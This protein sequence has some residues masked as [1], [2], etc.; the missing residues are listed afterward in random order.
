MN[1]LLQDFFEFLIVYMDD[2]V[3]FSKTRREHFQ[4]LRRVLQRFREAKFYVKKSKCEFCTKEIDFH[5]SA[6]GVTTQPDKIAAIKAWAEPKC[7]KDVRS[8]LGLTG[9]YQRYIPQ[10]AHIVTP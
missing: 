6:K 7:A 4:H 8:F 10:Y 1:F 5:I 3:I 9:F 2:I